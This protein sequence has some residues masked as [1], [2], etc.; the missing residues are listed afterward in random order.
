M[1]VLE[2]LQTLKVLSLRPLQDLVDDI[3]PPHE[4]PPQ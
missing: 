3:E 4:E 2:Q 1:E